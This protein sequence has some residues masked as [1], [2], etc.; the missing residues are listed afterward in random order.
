MS[1][2]DKIV[3]WIFIACGLGFTLYVALGGDFK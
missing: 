1:K 3:Y 2:K